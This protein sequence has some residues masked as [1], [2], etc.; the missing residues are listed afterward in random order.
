MGLPDLQPS[1]T[2]PDAARDGDPGAVAFVA[3][4]WIAMLVAAHVYVARF[5]TRVL[6]ADDLEMSSALAYGLSLDWL[7]QPLNE[8]RVLVPHLILYGLLRA[9]GDMRWALHLQVEILGLTAL[10][11]IV[12]ARR[13]RGAMRY[14]DAL[15]P[16]LLLH[17]GNSFNLLMGTQLALTIPTALACSILIAIATGPARPTAARVAWIGAALVVEPLCSGVGLLS[18]PAWI[19][20][21]AL[22]GLAL[23]RGPR[24]GRRLAV[25]MLGAALAGAVTIVVYLIGLRRPDEAHA[26]VGRTLD[27]A[28]RFLSTAFGPA[29]VEYF[30]VS[31][32]VVLAAGLAGLVVLVRVMRGEP[33]ERV[34]AGGLV[35]C[36]LAIAALALGIG[37]GRGG[38]SPVTGSALRYVTLPAPLL[39][40]AYLALVRYGPARLER[41]FGASLFA[42]AAVTVLVHVE[43]GERDGQ[44][45]LAAAI[46]LEREARAGA[47]P[48]MLAAAHWRDFYGSRPPFAGKLEELRRAG[49]APFEG[50][51]PPP[52][53]PGLPPYPMLRTQPASAAGGG[54]PLVR[55][56]WTVPVLA[57]PPGG[58][59][60]FAAPAGTRGL[61]ARFGLAGPRKR[62]RTTRFLV[63]L[64]L[65]G[66]APRVL[67]E[68][69]LDPATRDADRGFQEL[70]LELPPDVRD[71]AGELVLRT[72][73]D[74]PL[75]EVQGWGFWLDVE[76]LR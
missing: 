39:F 60:R 44:Q 38:A 65:E 4:A 49:F 52:E 68:R 56:A 15:F 22:A 73:S 27:T 63:E 57:V 72:L 2:V 42:L 37:W 32:A 76:V 13:L 54:P 74:V 67:F 41:F 21:L 62:T 19:A 48:E 20:W 24:G 66:E 1:R 8:H 64:D 29:G 69:T 3:V 35:A 5:G 53:G 36:A 34:R 16:L 11:L 51:P 55:L 23:W 71:R 70:A 50:S 28:F 14:A 31:S 26:G 9:T 30:P 43:V 12:A 61:R 58:E 18:A 25:G 33:R 7:W 59:L 40:T 45:H 10:A 46:T 6:F 47:S 17:W 75:D